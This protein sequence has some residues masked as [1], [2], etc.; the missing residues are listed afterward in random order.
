[1]N[2]RTQTTSDAQLEATLARIA[3]L[4]RFRLGTPKR[5][6]LTLLLVRRDGLFASHVTPTGMRLDADG[7]VASPPSGVAR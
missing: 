2:T 7:R 3:E 6:E 5:A 4:T 1:M